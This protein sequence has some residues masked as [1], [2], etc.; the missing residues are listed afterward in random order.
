ME[1]DETGDEDED[2]ADL[3]DEFDLDGE[4]KEEIIIAPKTTTKSKKLV[5]VKPV[6]ATPKAATPKAIK[7]PSKVAIPVAAA[8]GP[9]TPKTKTPPVASRLRGSAVK[10]SAAAKVIAKK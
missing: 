1:V 3:V 2:E 10:M 6:P 9:T 4:E 8:T 5:E 7:T